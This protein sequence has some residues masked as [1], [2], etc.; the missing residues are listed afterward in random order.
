VFPDFAA[1][2]SCGSFPIGVL[3]AITM[4]AAIRERMANLTLFGNLTI[5]TFH[6]TM[7]ISKDF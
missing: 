6:I 5:V 4:L 2:A 3:K 7:I 1:Y